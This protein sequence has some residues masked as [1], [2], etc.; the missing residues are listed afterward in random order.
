MSF[1]ATGDHQLSESYGLYGALCLA[2]GLD[3]YVDVEMIR[4]AG[5]SHASGLAG[6]TN[7]DVIRQGSADLGDAPYIARAFV[8][9]SHALGG[10]GMDTIGRAADDRPR[11]VLREFHPHAV[12]QL[13]ALSEYGVGLRRQY[14]RLFQWHRP[15]VDHA[16]VHASRRLI[17]DADRSQRQ[18]V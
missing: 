10:E 9:W 13:G 3:V 1:T 4:G 8:R 12:P 15:V 14:A 5:I 6:V 18:C 17:P 7:G 2:T 11:L 16:G